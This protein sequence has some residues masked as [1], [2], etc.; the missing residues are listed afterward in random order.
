MQMNISWARML[1]GGP[2][3]L[4]FTINTIDGQTYAQSSECIHSAQPCS[5]CCPP[6]MGLES[7]VCE[8]GETITTYKKGTRK[9]LM[10]TIQLHS[11][12][13]E[14]HVEIT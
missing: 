4:P 12:A 10:T 7:K 1:M 14:C 2:N 5:L 6:C 3:E 9:I 13:E 8:L 11:L